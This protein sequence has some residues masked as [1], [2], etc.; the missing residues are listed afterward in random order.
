MKAR[1]IVAWNLR[2]IRVERELTM[3][4]LAVDAGVDSSF[5]ARIERGVVNSSID[6]LERLTDALKVRLMELF[7]EP[8]PGAPKPST[9]KRGRRPSRTERQKP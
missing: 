9:M 3:D 4:E 2:R 5:V 8:L 7:V 6:T 1:K